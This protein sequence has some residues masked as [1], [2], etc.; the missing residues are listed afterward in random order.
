VVVCFG[1]SF[2]GVKYFCGVGLRSGSPFVFDIICRYCTF[3]FN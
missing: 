2:T 1:D 3:D